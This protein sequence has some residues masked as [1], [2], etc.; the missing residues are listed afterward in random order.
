MCKQTKNLAGIALLISFSI[1]SCTVNSSAF[2][3]GHFVIGGL[4]SIHVPGEA[5]SCS[6]INFLHGME[7]L[8][9]LLFSVDRI[10]ANKTFLPD[11]TL[12]VKAFDTC[13]RQTSALD[14]ALKEF[15]LTDLQN[16]GGSCANF[17]PSPVIGV[18][19]PGYS[20]EAIHVA[21]LLDIFEVPFISFSATSP[22]LSDK[23]KYEYFSRTVPSDS[24]QIQAIV[25]L[26]MHFNWTYVSVLYTDESYGVSSFE[27]FKQEAQKTGK[28]LT[29]LYFIYSKY[30]TFI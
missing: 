11:F 13:G 29:Y 5:G 24:L 23:S 7:V 27:G 10:N 12:G 25:D 22:E 1:A 4:I 2:I 15:V 18:I 3:P 16:S 9:A 19:G 28:F 6:V 8:E 21:T 26:L 17:T 30:S 20:Y 14:Q